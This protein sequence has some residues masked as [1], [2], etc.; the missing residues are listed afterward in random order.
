MY[1]FPN[2]RI[3][4]LINE[5]CLSNEK[6]IIFALSKASSDTIFKFNKEI[7]CISKLTMEYALIMCYRQHIPSL[8]QENFI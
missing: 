1:I 2:R 6:E 5:H 8:P 3:W 7:L 4:E